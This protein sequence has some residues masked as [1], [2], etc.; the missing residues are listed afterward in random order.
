MDASGL[1]PPASLLLSPEL[2]SSAKSR[3]APA[4]LRMCPDFV[5][6]FFGA[7]SPSST[8]PPTSRLMRP[9]FVLPHPSF[10]LRSSAPPPKVVIKYNMRTLYSITIEPLNNK[11]PTHK[12]IRC[13]INHNTIIIVIKIVYGLASLARGP[14]VRV[15]KH[16]NENLV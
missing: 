7:F 13:I 9:D 4:F 2:C 16:N 8:I 14:K 12:P 11:Y 15:I 10:C 1:C 5:D 6:C 3:N